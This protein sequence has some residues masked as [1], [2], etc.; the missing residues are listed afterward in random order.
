M[1]L[2]GMNVLITGASSGIGKACAVECNAEGAMVHLLG[3]DEGRLKGVY[4]GL[5]GDGN[6][7]H[8]LDLRETIGI[9]RKINEIVESYG[10]IDGF[11]HSAGYQITKPL[12][13]TKPEDYTDILTV[14]TI[15]AI[16]L[17]RCISKK[18]NV[19]EQG[20]SIVFISSIMGV[21]GNAGLTAY[22]ASKAALIGGARAMAI[23][24][25]PKKIR[26][27]CVSPAFMED[28]PM[29]KDLLSVLDDR[30]YAELM[31]GYPLGLGKTQDVSSMCAYLMSSKS[32]WITGQNFIIDGG[33]TAR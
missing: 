20:L 19:S 13:D 31:K 9:E 16:E 23:E 29:M 14:N 21:V 2:Q 17:S 6:S 18:K 10:K 11:I 4:H 25:A 24:L 1:L 33:Y 22:C 8:I 27:N 12:K 15:S 26:V 32:K 30:E 28:T 3:R 5:T 7:Y